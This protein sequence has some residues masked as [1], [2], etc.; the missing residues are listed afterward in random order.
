MTA[1][2]TRPT[3]QQT[4]RDLAS[5]FFI[6]KQVFLFTF[7][8]ILVGAL[9]LSFLSPPVYEADMQL[10][11]KPFNAKPLVFDEDSSRMNVFNEVSE[12]TLNTAI[13]MLTAPEVLR[14]V[15]L[16]HKLADANDEEAI[17]KEIEILKGSIKAGSSGTD[18]LGP[19]KRIHKIVYSIGFREAGSRIVKINQFAHIIS[20]ICYLLPTHQP[21]SPIL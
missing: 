19:I 7:F 1:S 14:D 21:Q 8:G 11:V 15:V 4:A 18:T 10:L 2:E 17:L 9:L 16:T 3:Q 6:K 5:I 20:F 12:K 13:F